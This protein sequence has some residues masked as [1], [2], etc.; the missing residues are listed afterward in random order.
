MNFKY[1]FS[2]FIKLIVN[3]INLLDF[4]LSIIRLRPS[5]IIRYAL[6]ESLST[7]KLLNQNFVTRTFLEENRVIERFKIEQDLKLFID[8]NLSTETIFWDIGACVGNFSIYA[9]HKL[10]KVIA[11]EPDG[12]TYSSLI[13]NVYRS[14]LVNITPLAIALGNEDKISDFNMQKFKIANAYNSAGNTLGQTGKH[15]EPEYTQNVCLFTA[16]KL[17]SEYNFQIPTHIKIDVD[18]NEIE[19]L[20]GF[21]DILGSKKINSIFIE[22]DIENP[23]S[24][25]CDA[26]LIKNGF[27]KQLQSMNSNIYNSIYKR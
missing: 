15:F 12:L 6:I 17:I 11:F 26:L 18:G 19:V 4:I 2:L 8:N 10:G 22:L 20:K 7:T 9:G 27:K 23:R 21:G 14:N 3:L 25:E 5:R 13:T 24:Q 1:Y 16:K